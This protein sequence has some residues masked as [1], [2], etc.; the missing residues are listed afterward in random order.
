[1]LLPFAIYGVFICL[2]RHSWLALHHL[3]TLGLGY[4]CVLAWMALR[5]KAE[6]RGGA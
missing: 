1:V 3:L 2:A 5:R 6:G 4:A